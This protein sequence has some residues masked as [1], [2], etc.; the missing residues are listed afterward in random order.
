MIAN[1]NW[2]YSINTYKPR[3]EV[4]QNF[5]SKMLFFS[6][7]EKLRR[8][9]NVLSCISFP[10]KQICIHKKIKLIIDIYVQISKTSL[11]TFEN[12]VNMQ[13]NVLNK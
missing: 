8:K 6:R 10:E 9:Y 11:R 3:K 12:I 2:L 13:Y 5:H 7:N 4:K 1:G